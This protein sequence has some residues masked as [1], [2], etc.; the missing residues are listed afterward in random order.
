MVVF[1][2]DIVQ[3]V[4]S[5]PLPKGA[6]HDQVMWQGDR[7]NKFSVIEAYRLCARREDNSRQWDLNWIWKLCASERIR[8]WLWRV[9][10]NGI[11]TKA[12]LSRRGLVINMRCPRC[13]IF[14]EDTHLISECHW[15]KQIWSSLTSM[16]GTNLSVIYLSKIG[17]S[18][19]MVLSL[20][21]GNELHSVNVSLY[22]LL[23]GNKGTIWI[24]MML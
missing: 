18:M 6:A 17:G 22:T 2:E 11:S 5:I 14:A 12:F 24:L 21:E 19:L 1:S 9:R 3:K 13:G 15:S 8:A 10:R 20:K 23:D 7:L 16:I 4:L